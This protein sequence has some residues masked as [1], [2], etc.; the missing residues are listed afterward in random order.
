MLIRI[1][2]QKILPLAILAYSNSSP[3]MWISTGQP[4]QASFSLSDLLPSGPYNRL[5][6]YINFRPFNSI[7]ILNGGGLDYG[8]SF[9]LRAFESG[10]QVF[11]GSYSYSESTPGSVASSFGSYI[12]LVPAGF[13]DGLGQLIL[14]IDGVADVSGID[15]RGIRTDITVNSSTQFVQAA[16]AVVAAPEP[17]PIALL[18]AAMV[19][20]MIFRRKASPGA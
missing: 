5:E 15:V 16:F 19:G 12:S 7:G 13:A 17:A 9:T 14:T 11:L 6:F 8:E 3:A 1:I 4:V 2:Y 10:A 20:S 18:G